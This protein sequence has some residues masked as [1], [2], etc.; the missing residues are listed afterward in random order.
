M[1]ER[2]ELGAAVG[3]NDDVVIVEDV[4]DRQD[5]RPPVRHK[6]QPADVAAPEERDALARS[7][8]GGRVRRDGRIGPRRWLRAHDATS[9][10]AMVAAWATSRRTTTSIT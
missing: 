5:C 7:Q 1:A 8:H 9:A 6:S 10:P 4:V 3:T 2:R